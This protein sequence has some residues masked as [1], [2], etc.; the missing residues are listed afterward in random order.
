MLRHTLLALGLCMTPAFAA[1]TSVRLWNQPDNSSFTILQ[2]HKLHVFALEF[3]AADDF[4]V[5]GSIGKVVVAGSFGVP[6]STVG[7]VA[8]AHVRFY[9]WT[10][11]GP[12]ALLFHDVIP[13]SDP[14][15]GTHALTL[16]TPYVSNGKAYVSVQYEALPN[17]VIQFDWS[18]AN[19]NAPT[20]GGACQRVNGGAWS[21]KTHDLVL[22]L[23]SP[24]NL[25][26]AFGNDPC[27]TWNEIDTPIWPSN[28]TQGGFSGIDV[29]GHDDVWAVGQAAI[30]NPGSSHDAGIPLAMHWD[31]TSWTPTPTPI[32]GPLPGDGDSTFYAVKALATNDVWAAGWQEI[33]GSGQFF[34]VEILAM[35]WDG[36]QWSIV[37]TPIPGA[38]VGGPSGANGSHVTAIDGVASDDVWFVGMWQQPVPAGTFLEHGLAMHWDGSQMTVHPT[39]YALGPNGFTG[40]Y[41][42][43]DVIAFA[44]NDVWAVGNGL[45]TWTP[46]PYVLRW[47]GTQ[48]GLVN[49]P[50]VGP[51]FQFHEIVG[52][53]SSNLYVSGSVR[54]ANNVVTNVLMH[55]DGSQ[56]TQHPLPQLGAS[57][58]YMAPSGVL[59]ATNFGIDR[60]ENG[61]WTHV[62]DVTTNQLQP[63]VGSI[64]GF[65]ECELYTVASKSSVNLGT[66]PFSARLFPDLWSDLGG[67]APGLLGTP[68]L[69]GEGAPLAGSTVLVSL[70]A[71]PANAFATMFVGLGPLGV[72]AFGGTFWPQPTIVV[73]GL[74]TNAAGKLDLWIDWPVGVPS[75]VQLYLQDWIADPSAPFGVTG[76]NGLFLQTP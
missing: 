25:P 67:G 51:S 22:E 63:L 28:A 2:S 40:G 59:Y 6:I 58:L 61:V 76:S 72:P 18:D 57:S 21:Q 23:W 34:G 26:P 54:D 5:V 48:W 43:N 38:S 16:H 49:V 62:A 8:K 4:D 3:E 36:A 65:D 12:G 75:G 55:F 33:T 15:Y 1:G 37:P 44:S 64:D 11:T 32:L 10:P 74:P 14:N 24:A 45:N 39:P 73:A 70:S 56:W 52:T 9:A 42:L 71:A 30:P 29:L 31:G 17:D 66:R 35:H 50:L 27:G 69:S 60:F 68:A 7:K 47:D 46:V 19:W 13:K 41:I 53:S 20:L